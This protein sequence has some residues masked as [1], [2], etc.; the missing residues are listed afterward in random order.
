MKIFQF[1]RFLFGASRYI[2]WSLIIVSIALVALMLATLVTTMSNRDDIDSFSKENLDHEQTSAD[3]YQYILVGALIVAFIASLLLVFHNKRVS[4][5][6]SIQN[7]QSEASVA[8]LDQNTQEAIQRRRQLD[9]AY[10]GLENRYK[11]LETEN[12]KLNA[13]SH[14]QI[15]R[16]EHQPRRVGTPEQQASARHIPVEAPEQETSPSHIPVVTPEQ[17]TSARHIPPAKEQW[18]IEKL[19]PLRGKSIIVTAMANDRESIVFARELMKYFSSA[20]WLTTGLDQLVY[21]G[22]P[23]GLQWRVKTTPNPLAEYLAA[24]FKT[25]GFDSSILPVTD[26]PVGDIELN[27]LYKP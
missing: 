20:G 24:N 16:V 12:L 11:E 27:V 4:R 15:A 14:E 23:V 10:K 25:L 5:L 2:R 6:Q 19:A 18:L 17:Q 13:R 3:W 9:A 22:K 7:D 21:P 1:S 8:T 26:L